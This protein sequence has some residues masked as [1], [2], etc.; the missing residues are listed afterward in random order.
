MPS[1]V[2]SNSPNYTM[3]QIATPFAMWAGCRNIISRVKDDRTEETR[4]SSL[5]LENTIT[6]VTWLRCLP[7]ITLY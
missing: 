5:S 2:Q 1:G 4:S 7:L 3:N 6:Q